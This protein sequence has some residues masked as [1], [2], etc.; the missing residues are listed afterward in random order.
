MW[1]PFIHR[2][3]EHSLAASCAENFDIHSSNRPRG[4]EEG[5]M[6]GGEMIHKQQLQV[7]THHD[8]QVAGITSFSASTSCLAL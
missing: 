2:I 6:A 5:G 4:G 8:H 1:S 7:R 3:C